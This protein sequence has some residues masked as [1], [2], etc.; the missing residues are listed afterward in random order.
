MILYKYSHLKML[1]KQLQFCYNREGESVKCL[2][3]ISISEGVVKQIAETVKPMAGSARTF[4][5][6]EAESFVRNSIKV[7]P[8][9]SSIREQASSRIVSLIC[10]YIECDER[11]SP[12]SSLG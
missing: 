6:N 10:T 7:I 8:K 2:L 12:L 1:S 3:T 9:K 5:A 4:T 11:Y